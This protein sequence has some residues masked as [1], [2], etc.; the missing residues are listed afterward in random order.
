MTFF[1]AILSVRMSIRADSCKYGE[2]KT[3]TMEDDNRKRLLNDALVEY[4]D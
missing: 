2:D 1:Y 4:I 3:E